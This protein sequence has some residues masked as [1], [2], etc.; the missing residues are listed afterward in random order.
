METARPEATETNETAL[1]RETLRKDIAL[2][3]IDNQ[4]KV[5]TAL[6]QGG[7]VVVALLVG[8]VGWRNFREQ[9]RKVEIDREVQRHQPLHPGDRATRRRAKGRESEPGGAVGPLYALERLGLT[10]RRTA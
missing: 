2:F 3:R 10:R 9:Q 1:L 5:W 8:Y 4:I 6:V 7:T